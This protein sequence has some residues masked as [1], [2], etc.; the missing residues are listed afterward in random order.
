MAELNKQAA[1]DKIKD[2][3]YNLIIAPFHGTPV[4]VLVRLLT[5]AQLRACGSFSVIETFKDKVKRAAA[6]KKPTLQDFVD[7]AERQ[8]EICRRALVK[9]TYDEMIEN[10]T[11]SSVLS[12]KEKLKKLKAKVKDTPRGEEQKRLLQEIDGLTIW[13]D[14]LLPEDFTATITSYVLGV[15]R[16]DIKELTEDMLYEAAILARNGHDNPA[17]HLSGNY[18]REYMR[19]EINRRA[20]SI[21][22][23]RQ[24][25]ENGG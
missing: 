18:P 22:G 5:Q 3:K 6:E 24:K 17:D 8:H 13:T 23:E 19:D 1:L 7:Y 11:D 16:S 4:P 21:Y 25:E 14:L 10:I 12:A 2:G 20:W 9:P 15:D